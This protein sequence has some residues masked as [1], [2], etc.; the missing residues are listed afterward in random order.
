MIIKALKK[1]YNEIARVWEASVRA[2]HHFLSEDYLQEIKGLLPA[3]FPAIPMYIFRNDQDEIEGFLGV[4]DK[5]I[6]MLFIRPEAMRKG[7]GRILTDFAIN[8]LKADK[9][10][11]N[12]Q[13]GQAVAFYLRMGFVVDARTEEDGMGRPFPLLQMK[14]GNVQI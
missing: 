9:V 10:D 1:D 3:I 14:L 7:I 5:K 2:T 12:E 13:N 4:K 6:E 11:V 8:E